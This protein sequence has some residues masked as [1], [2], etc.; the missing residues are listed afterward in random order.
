MKRFVRGNKGFTLVEL[1]IVVAILAILAGVV[2]P[3]VIGLMGRGGA[4]A[5]ETDEEVIQLASSTFYS[6]VHAGFDMTNASATNRWND[7]NAGNISGHWYPTFLGVATDHELV[8]SSTEFDGEGNPMLEIIGAP[9]TPAGD[10]DISD[11]AIWMGLLINQDG[12][13]GAP[14]AGG[15]DDRYLAS[16]LLDET[17]LYLQELPESSSALNSNTDAAGGGYTWVVGRNG[18][19]FGAYPSVTDA[20]LSAG[21]GDV[22]GWFAGFSGGYP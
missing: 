6:D 14:V 18:Q 11:H 17:S 20:D 12:D 9:G 5:Y 22:A 2:I 4:Q 21:P 3:N 15:T 13:F 19:V 16:P 1:L 10:P 8:L 7:S